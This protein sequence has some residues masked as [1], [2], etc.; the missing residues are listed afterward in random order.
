MNVYNIGITYL[1]GKESVRKLKAGDRD[2]SEDRLR[3]MKKTRLWDTTVPTTE[4]DKNS[5]RITDLSQNLGKNGTV[6]NKIGSIRPKLD[7]GREGGG[8]RRIPNP[9]DGL[10]N[11]RDK[12]ESER[13][14]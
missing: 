3:K 5:L 10:R 7:F 4:C 1:F 11:A 6:G 12:N 2:S 13:G 8:L 14:G 9:H